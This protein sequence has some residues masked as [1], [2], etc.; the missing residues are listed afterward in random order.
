MSASVYFR[1][2]FT[3]KYLDE[4]YFSSVRF[5]TAIGI[6]KINRK[7]F[8]ENIDENIDVIYRKIRKG[9]YKFTTYREKLISRG[10]K[11][12]PR[13]VSIPTIRDKLA[14]KALYEILQNVYDK[15][16]PFVHQ[17]INDI[18][19][20]IDED[21]YDGV[22]KLDV[23]D[24]Y[25]S[26]NHFSLF[27]QIRRRIRKPEILTCI[28][29][30][31]RQ[32]TVVKIKK[33]EISDNTV[34]VPQ[35]LSISNVLANIYFYPV[36]K[37]YSEKTSIKYFRYVDDILI[38]CKC[39]ET[40]RFRRKIKLDCKKIKLRLHD[41]DSEKSISCHITEGFSYLGYIF[42]NGKITVREKSLDH[43]RESIIRVFTNYKYSKSHDVD[44]LK[45]SVNIRITG[46]IFNG[47]KY[48]WLFFFSQINDLQLLKSLDIFVEKLALRFRGKV[49]M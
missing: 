1:K 48:G 4:L 22:V 32:P 2:I 5:K 11:K 8:E 14:L 41:G 30:A 36:D 6:D 10:S 49:K 17:I 28:K 31:L 33:G 24:F 20:I 34:G 27:K 3:K 26:I 35:G 12:I 40:E 43:L 21:V 13:V 47:T 16:S 29:N 42:D 39:S 15:E 23:K 9:S 18:S 7:V 37:I 19:S 38:L 25:P 46:C 44:L 45:W